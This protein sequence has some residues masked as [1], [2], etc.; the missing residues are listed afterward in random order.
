MSFDVRVTAL[1]YCLAF[2]VTIL[3]TLMTNAAM[4]RRLAAVNMAES[5]KS[6]E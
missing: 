4:K 2:A 6:V 1:S 5:L 3:F